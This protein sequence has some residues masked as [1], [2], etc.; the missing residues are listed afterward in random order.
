MDYTS[1]PLLIQCY[2]DVKELFES[3][4]KRVFYT[5][6]IEVLLEKRYFHWL[7]NK[8]IRELHAA[9]IILMEEGAMTTGGTAKLYWLKSHRYYKRGFNEVLSL[10]DEFSSPDITAT[11]GDMGELLVC[12]AFCRNGF[13]I[14]STEFN[15]YDGKKWTETAHDIDFLFERD[16]Q[17]YGVEIKNTLPYMETKEFNIKVAMCNHLGIRPLFVNRYFPG[18]FA[19]GLQMNGGFA[20]T[21]KYQ[22][23]PRGLKDLVSRIQDT[24]DL[25]V[26][27]P[28]RIEQGTMDRLLNWHKK[29]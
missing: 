16:G 11:I 1:D 19:R 12:E 14:L 25:P 4:P 5:R 29:L 21:M 7:T 26:D 15:E 18:N 23:Y 20:F 17:A 24:L 2:E 10:I 27:C 13:S 28:R 3:N 22:F 6:Q 8:A 9:G